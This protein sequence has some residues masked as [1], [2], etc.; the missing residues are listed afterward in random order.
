MK[1]V[2]GLSKYGNSRKTVR[3][4]KD[5]REKKIAKTTKKEKFLD[6]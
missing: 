2:Y 6:N 3:K 1:I 5:F 4:R